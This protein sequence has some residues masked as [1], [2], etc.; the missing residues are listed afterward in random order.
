MR[1]QTLTVSVIWSL[2]GLL[3]LL[4]I[5]LFFPTPQIKISDMDA[6]I[7]KTV[8]IS[9]DVSSISYSEKT[10]FLTLSDG[11]GKIPAVFFSQVENGVTKGDKVAVKGKIQLYQGDPELIISELRCL[12]C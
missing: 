8:I 1:N 7:G 10:T 11:T 5:S 2:S 4:L 6:N 3:I 9:A 12:S